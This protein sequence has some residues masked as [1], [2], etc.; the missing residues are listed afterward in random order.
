MDECGIC[1]YFGKHS[2]ADNDL[3]ECR[4]Y[5][6]SIVSALVIPLRDSEGNAY[7]VSDNKADATQFPILHVSDLCGE[8]TVRVDAD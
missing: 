6:P 7:N 3:G 4:R 8:F 1:R 5:P 2:S